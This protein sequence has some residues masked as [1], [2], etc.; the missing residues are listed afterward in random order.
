[1]LVRLFVGGIGKSSVMFRLFVC[2]IGK[3]S[4]IFLGD[5]K[6]IETKTNEVI[7]GSDCDA[8]VMRALVQQFISKY[9]DLENL[10]VYSGVD[11][12]KISQ[13]DLSMICWDLK[14]I[15]EK[16]EVVRCED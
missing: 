9:D 16:L 7:I 14:G 2:G 4:N 6:M 10:V 15:V 3:H 8:K 11:F 12:S 1:M 13:F 5:L